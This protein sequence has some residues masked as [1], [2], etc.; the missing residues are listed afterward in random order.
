M[1][2][3]ENN[4]NIATTINTIKTFNYSILDKNIQSYN[5]MKWFY[6]VTD[7]ILKNHGTIFGGCTRDLIIRESACEKFRI[8]CVENDLNLRKEYNK[9]DCHPET[10]IDRTIIPNDIDV[11][12]TLNNLNNI[13]VALET[14]GVII[15]IPSKGL[16]RASPGIKLNKHVINSLNM[17]K[18]EYKTPIGKFFYEMSNMKLN[19]D[20]ITADTHKE[21][22]TYLSVKP[23]FLCNQIQMSIDNDIELIIYKV[24]K[25]ILLMKGILEYERYP[26]NIGDDSESKIIRLF[27]IRNSLENSN[28]KND[29]LNIIIYQILNK[30]AYAIFPDSRRIEKMIKEGW[31]IIFDKN[32][33]SYY[34]KILFK[35]IKIYYNN[36]IELK[37]LDTCPI[38]IEI[39]NHDIFLDSP[40]KICSN[41]HYVHIKCF[42]KAYISQYC[43]QEVEPSCCI[44][45][46]EY[47]EN[48][49]ELCKTIFSY[50]H[51]EEQYELLNNKKINVISHRE[52][53]F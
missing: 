52:I 44:C 22:E 12:C 33:L 45:R 16:Y 7:L 28:F 47:S 21:L 24:P 4:D 17:Y 23:D 50:M 27:D 2:Q 18:S 10:F 42:V 20:I 19:I 15:K 30:K 34:Y 41:S 43:E 3:E 51:Y 25:N 35:N 5:Y 29:V 11:Y 48:Y 8:F 13:Y 1:D 40:I 32:I 39:Y 37:Q 38:C 9:S 46:E 14:E 49:K 31:K 53:N 26:I 36:I 6:R